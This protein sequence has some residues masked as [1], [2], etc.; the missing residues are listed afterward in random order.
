MSISFT[1]TA[2]EV[3]TKALNDLGVYSPGEDVSAEDMAT[4][5][6]ALNLML[7]SWGGR[8]ITCWTD[9]DGTATITGGN[10][11]VTLSPRPLFVTEARVVITATNERP[12]S[13]WG[14]A[15]YA[16]LPNKAAVGT[17][18][19]FSLRYTPSNVTMRVWPVPSSDM[20]VKY[21]FARVI[22]DVGGTT[23]AIDVPQEWLECVVKNLAVNLPSFGAVRSNPETYGEIKER[24]MI[25]LRDLED[26]SRPESYSMGAA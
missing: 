18:T 11:S 15:D 23:D 16:R 13:E 1:M 5:L 7:K 17:P 6:E 8:G 2:G 19:I 25:L 20:T 14:N 21:G 10:A 22:E 9:I 4:G 12:L 26:L 24:A 3:V